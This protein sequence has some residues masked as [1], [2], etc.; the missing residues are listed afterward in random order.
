MFDIGWSELPHRH[1]CA[2]CNRPE[3]A[4]RIAY[5]GAMDREA[6]ADGVGVPDQFHEAM[7]EAEMADLKQVDEDDRPGERGFDPDW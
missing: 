2:D 4:R 1:C 7:R 3:S 6:P 5:A